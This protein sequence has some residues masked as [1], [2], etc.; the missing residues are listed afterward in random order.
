MNFDEA[1]HYIDRRL[2]FG[3]KLGNERFVALLALLDDPH[4]KLKVIHIAGTKGKGST[5]AMT[6]SILLESG[7]KVGLYLSPYVF[8][9]RERVQINGIPIP[10]DDFARIVTRM[11]PLVEQIEK[12]EH[13]PVTEFEFK[14]AVGFCYFEEQDVDLAVIEVGLGGRLDA[15]NVFDHP[16]ITVI[17]NIGLDHTEILGE[18]T[19]EIARE[20]AGILKHNVVCVTGEPAGTD[21]FR[22]ITLACQRHSALLV[23]IEE[24]AASTTGR[25]SFLSC[26]NE[27]VQLRTPLRSLRPGKLGMRGQFQHA[28]AAVAATVVDLLPERYRSAISEDSILRGLERCTL[29]GRMQRVLDS[30]TVLLDVAHNEM[31][32]RVLARAL[33]EQYHCKERRTVLIVGMK[34][35]H[36][37]DTFLR[38]LADLKPDVLIA[39][40][41][42]F[43]PR[44]AEEIADCAVTLGISDVRVVKSSVESA[45]RT[46]L[47]LCNASDLICLTGSFYTVGQIT[48]EHWRQLASE[49]K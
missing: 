24:C 9:I 11:R 41:P 3:V 20:K 33:S 34:K 5:S 44:P 22:E 12:T 13:G 19:A 37:P 1:Q 42:A 29:P 27:N 28:N 30:P 7:F 32:A 14:T 17:T 38:P 16:L 35:N 25:G 47:A 15:T 40:Q 48:P 6:A 2:R 36:A 46:A 26:P 10:E 18:T 45:A 49:R 4:K 21:A 8:N 23:P 39:T 43:Q 31:S